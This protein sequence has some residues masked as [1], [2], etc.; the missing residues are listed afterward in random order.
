MA[1][2]TETEFVECDCARG[3]GYPACSEFW[4]LKR[5]GDAAGAEEHRSG[6][7]KAER[8]ARR[9]AANNGNWVVQ[10]QRMHVP[11]G[12]IVAL[13]A[14]NDNQCAMAARRYLTA[15]RDL[16]PVLALVGP[17]GVGKTVAAAMVLKDFAERFD[18][19]RPTGETRVPA[20]F[21]EAR[22][23]SRLSAFDSGDRELF[24]NARG[25][26]L[27]V[28]DDLGDE[29]HDFGKA[30]LVDLLMERIDR[31]RATVIT[32]N[33]SMEA[34]RKRYGEALF[35]R[36]KTRAVIPALTGKS[37]REKREVRQ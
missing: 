15:P 18:W 35:D 5:S 1:E 19:D 24:N 6:A 16:L 10:L 27:L 3:G 28:L 14:P 32:S 29:A 34:F 12:V 25:C 37:L 33:L 36:V 4:R 22:R 8:D 20:V 30:Q 23:L 2:Q 13:R 26:R 11:A 17:V 31:K 21:L 9:D 7:V